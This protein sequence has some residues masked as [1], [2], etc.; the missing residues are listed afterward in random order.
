MRDVFLRSRDKLVDTYP[1]LA[2]VSLED[3][4]DIE[5]RSSLTAATIKGSLNPDAI[6][7][8]FRVLLQFVTRRVRDILGFNPINKIVANT[9]KEIQTHYP[10]TAY[11]IEWE[12]LTAVKSS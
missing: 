8:G 9:R 7:D 11:D 4:V 12:C 5:L 3:G 10:S 2:F 1:W 6:N